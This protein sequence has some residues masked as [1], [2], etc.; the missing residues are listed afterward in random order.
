MV[1][2]LAL[3]VG[4]LLLLLAAACATSAHGE[5]APASSTPAGC[6]E[7]AKFCPETKTSVERDPKLNCEFPACPVPA[8]PPPTNTGTL[9]SSVVAV[10]H[11]RNRTR[12]PVH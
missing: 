12:V 1:G 11:R 7:D 10:V 4:S 9:R 5:D 8:T 2:R 6:R 3:R